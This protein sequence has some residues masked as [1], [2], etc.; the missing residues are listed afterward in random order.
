VGFSQ[1][2]HL[3]Y[4]TVD[5]LPINIDAQMDITKLGFS[6]DTFD[7]IVCNHVLEHI[8]DDYAAMREL[9]R[10]LKPGGWALL[11]VP[12]SSQATTYED[13]SIVLP[14]DRQRAF[15]QPDHL[16]LYGHDYTERLESCGFEVRVDTFASELPPEQRA[17][18]RLSAEML[19]IGTK[20]L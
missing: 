4:L 2:E 5:L 18:Y 16:R 6:P 9:Y 19:Y 1:L 3:T 11:Q 20:T 7:V 12:M 15:G 14:E 8:P 13:P 17:R 10:V